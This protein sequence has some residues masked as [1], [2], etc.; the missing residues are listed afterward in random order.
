MSNNNEWVTDYV[1]RAGK[2]IKDF[3]KRASRDV[4]K[5]HR[6]NYPYIVGAQQVI[7]SF[8]LH[9]IIQLLLNQKMSKTEVQLRIDKIVQ[10]LTSTP[11]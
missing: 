9:E 8:L 6:I 1:S 5:N 11:S 2:D 10:L 7:V 4:S 3:L